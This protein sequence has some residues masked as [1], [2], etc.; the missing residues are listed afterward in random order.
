MRV[1]HLWQPNDSVG[2][3]GHGERTPRKPKRAC[4]V[5]CPLEARALLTARG[6]QRRSRL[7]P[8]LA[9]ALLVIACSSSND[10]DRGCGAGIG[11]R[12]CES[13][14]DCEGFTGDELAL[15]GGRDSECVT[16]TC[17]DKKC[18]AAPKT[19]SLPDKI[20][21]DCMK[22]VCK[23]GHRE[24]VLE[25]GDVGSTAAP[26]CE[27]VVCEEG[28]LGGASRTT[29]PVYDGTPCSL[30]PRAGVC[31]NGRCVEQ[32]EEDAGADA[33]EVDASTD[34]GEVDASKDA[35]AD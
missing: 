19:G 15:F 6:M 14:A 26:E 4:S 32:T 10:D 17:H 8:A 7:G 2:R 18:N 3:Q 22:S 21:G 34:A 11:E 20:D 35:E 13:N 25:R 28:F 12:A 24:D 5:C 23:D 16:A 9:L 29:R 27:R 31:S 1:R 33:G 30:G